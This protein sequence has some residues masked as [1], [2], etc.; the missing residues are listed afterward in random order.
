[1]HPAN[2]ERTLERLTA[3]RAER[4]Q[5]PEVAHEARAKMAVAEHVLAERER[6][7]ATAARISPPDYIKAELGERPRDAAKAREWD[8]AVRGIEGYR[9]RNGVRDRRNALGRKPKDHAA[10]AKQRRA[11]ERLQLAQRQLGLKRQLERAASQSLGRG[12]GR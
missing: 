10:E 7:A 6:L 8:K 11:R 2:G 5:L 12:I 4:E 1:V 9:T 3:A